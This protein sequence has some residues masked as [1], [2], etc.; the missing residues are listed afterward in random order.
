MAAIESIDE[1]S[2]LSRPG[3][4]QGAGAKELIYTAQPCAP[5]LLVLHEARVAVANAELFAC[6]DLSQCHDEEDSLV[7]LDALDDGDVGEAGMVE[8][9][10]HGEDAEADHSYSLPFLLPPDAH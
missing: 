6:L 9:A 2:L 1:V 8:E 10:D 5:L 7:P 4:A 3:R